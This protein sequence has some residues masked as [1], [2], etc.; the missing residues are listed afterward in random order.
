MNVSAKFKEKTVWI[1]GA[2]SGIG[3]ALAYHLGREGARLI[4]S[5]NEPEELKRVEQNCQR[6]KM[7]VATLELLL[8]DIDALPEKATKALEIFGGLDILFNNG[9]ISQ[10]SLARDTS[11]SVDQKI[12][13]INYLGQVALTKAVLPHMIRKRSGHIVV[14][15]SV[16]GLIAV[17]L[18]TAYCA[19]K[20]ALHGFFEALRFEVLQEGIQVTLVCPAAVRTKIADNALVGNGTKYGCKDMTIEAGITPEECAKKIA[21]AVAKG[22]Q[23]VVIGSGAGRF[24][25]YLNRISPALFSFILQHRGIA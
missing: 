25:V 1:T 6:Q 5:S 2:S 14:T 4:L 11:I 23:L 9:G 8:E 10:R 16:M 21:R 13:S 12:M 7:A 15:S 18:R 19:A 17:P 3:E 22:K 24:G 20:H